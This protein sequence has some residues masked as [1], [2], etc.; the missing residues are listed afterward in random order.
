[1]TDQD[2][3]ARRYT[4]LLRLYPKDYRDSYGAELVDTL[5]TTK[6]SPTAESLNLVGGAIT[7]RARR[8]RRPIGAPW[9]DALAITGLL[10]PILSVAGI[11]AST[12]SVAG[13]TSWAAVA[14]LL[15]LAWPIVLV[16]GLLGARRTAMIGGWLVAVATVVAL[17]AQF[18]GVEVLRSTD[19]VPGW[20][21]LAVIAA[22]TSAGVRRGY[23]L[24]GRGRTVLVGA[25]VLLVPV[26]R[27]VAHYSAIPYR[28]YTLVQ[29][30][31]LVVALGCATYA[32]WRGR[33]IGRRVAVLFVT[34]VVAIGSRL[35]LN[36]VAPLGLPD[37]P[38]TVVR[39]LPALAVLVLLGLA[40]GT[41]LVVRR[42]PTVA[43]D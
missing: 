18:H 10:A 32:A 11:A 5:L 2:R 15:A 8:L 27:V 17:N 1:M 36:R 31:T 20:S 33:S 16:L 12:R 7:A 24:V 14:G 29:W 34:P 35:V 22:T 30:G 42:K 4:R 6:R 28:E 23:E 3:L 41:T 43:S 19:Q 9:R 38:P 25:A 37:W 26:G 21:V 40:A 13:P 39:Y